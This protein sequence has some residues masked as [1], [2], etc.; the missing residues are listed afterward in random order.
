MQYRDIYC[1]VN[2]QGRQKR[3]VQSFITIIVAHVTTVQQIW[4]GGDQN[5]RLLRRFV[6]K[7]MGRAHMEGRESYI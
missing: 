3:T 7:T 1:T 5:V 4:M 2:G 6:S